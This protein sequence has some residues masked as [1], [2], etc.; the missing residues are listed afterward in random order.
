MK[1]KDKIKRLI[2]ILKNGNF[3]KFNRYNSYLVR[4]TKQGVNLN[5]VN[6]SYFDFTNFSFIG[7]DLKNVNFSNCNLNGT[8]FIG[9]DLRSAD[10]RNSNLTNADFRGAKLY[11]ANLND[12]KTQNTK[13]GAFI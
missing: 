10:L 3:K 9:A 1:K 4:K 12:A 8:F 13:F 2:T 5:G 11:C 7:A 6:L